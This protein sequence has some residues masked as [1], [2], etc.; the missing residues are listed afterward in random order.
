MEELAKYISEDQEISYKD[1]LNDLSHENNY[2]YGLDVYSYGQMEYA[3]GTDS[4]C[5]IAEDDYLSEY[6]NE[7]ILD[8]IP[9]LYKSYF[10]EEKWKRDAKINGR[11]Y[12]LSNYD[13]NE[14][15]LDNGLFAY[16]IN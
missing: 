10:D 14:I 12:A 9:E 2:Y 16:R 5:E 1:V 4:Q 7:S 15:E 6:I 13:G 3:V 8:E 11:G